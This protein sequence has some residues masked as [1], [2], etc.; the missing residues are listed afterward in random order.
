MSVGDFIAGWQHNSGSCKFDPEGSNIS[1][2]STPGLPSD[3]GGGGAGGDGGNSGG[4]TGGG[5]S[6]ETTGS[7]SLLYLSFDISA[8]IPQH[9]VS[10]I[11]CPAT[12]KSLI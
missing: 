11:L 10:S 7:E 8:T 12:Q 4:G 3:S 6:N 5:M 9:R 2:N 1:E